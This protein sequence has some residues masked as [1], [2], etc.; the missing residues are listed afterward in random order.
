MAADNSSDVEAQIDQWRSYLHSRQAI[1]AT[2]VEE[3][4][5]HLRDQVAELADVGLQEDEAFL[6]AV[7]G[8]YMEP[9]EDGSRQ[10]QRC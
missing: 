6:V 9:D 3:L 8:Y 10:Q 1:H 4:E 7:V 2:D 5:G